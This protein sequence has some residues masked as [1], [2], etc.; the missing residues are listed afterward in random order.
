MKGGEKDHCAMMKLFEVITEQQNNSVYT[1]TNTN[2]WNST[3]ASKLLGLH[4]PIGELSAI[5][6]NDG[7]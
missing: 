6:D 7:V 1:H 5:N 4:N 2:T 3:S